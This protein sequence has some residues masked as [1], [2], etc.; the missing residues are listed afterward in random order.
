MFYKKKP[1]VIEA[2]Q[3]FGDVRQT[4]DPEWIVE[5]LENEECFIDKERMTLSIKTL[6]GIMVANQGDY[7]I[8]GVK[9]EI[10]PCKPYIFNETYEKA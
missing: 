4:E 2:F 5:K 7:I 9:G 8:K 3:W 1:V 10:Y 6:E